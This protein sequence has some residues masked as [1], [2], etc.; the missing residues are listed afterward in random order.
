VANSAL[1]GGQAAI[2]HQGLGAVNG[3]NIGAYQVNFGNTA[4]ADGG[5]APTI[6]AQGGTTGTWTVASTL[7]RAVGLSSISGL[8][9][10]SWAAADGATPYAY[11]TVVQPLTIQTGIIGRTSLP[12][13]TSGIP[14]DG[15]V[16]IALYYL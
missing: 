4:T 7:G 6:Y 11:T 8:R 12:D 15:S 5:N 2:V 3:T 9:Y 1:I 10:F 16:T 13:M 14:L